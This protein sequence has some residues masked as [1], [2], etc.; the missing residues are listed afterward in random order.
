MS[1]DEFEEIGWSDVESMNE[2][3]EAEKRGKEASKFVAKFPNEQRGR[4]NDNDKKSQVLMGTSIPLITLP[5][6]EIKI[7]LSVEEVYEEEDKSGSN[8]HHR[9]PNFTAA[10]RKSTILAGSSRALRSQISRFEDA[11]FKEH[12]RPP[13]RP[14]DRAPMATTY[15][16][17]RKWKKEIRGDAACRIQALFRG[18]STRSKNR[19]TVHCA[20]GS[21]RIILK[22]ADP[23]LSEFDINQTSIPDDTMAELQ[24]RKSDLKLQLKTYNTAFAHKNGRMPNKAEKEPIRYLYESYNRLKSQ[25]K[26]LKQEHCSGSDGGMSDGNDASGVAALKEEKKR[27]HAKLKAYEKEFFQ[28]N[29]RQVLSFVDIEPVASDYRRYKE[30]KKELGL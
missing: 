5:K 9:I 22:R 15:A 1:N 17:Y 25:I 28:K 19:I 14:A 8:H 20:S 29:Q 16:Q 10:E 6:Q 3:E 13:K 24:A 11:F 21:T 26:E 30:V 2:D 12:G 23:S 7:E 27:L 18:S 4:R